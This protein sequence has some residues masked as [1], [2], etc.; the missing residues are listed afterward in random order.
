MK[1]STAS[2]AYGLGNVTFLART[3]EEEAY[4]QHVLKLRAEYIHRLKLDEMFALA[5]PPS[6]SNELFRL[7][8]YCWRQLRV[9]M[10]F[11]DNPAVQDSKPVKYALEIFSGAKKIVQAA[12]SYGIWRKPVIMTLDDVYNG[13]VS[14]LLSIKAISEQQHNQTIGFA[15]ITVPDFFNKTLS[16]LLFEAARDVC[17]QSA[18]MALSRTIAAAWGAGVGG[19][20]RT[21]ILDQGQHHMT[22]RTLE[23]PAVRP[24][25]E[26]EIIVQRVLP[27]DPYSSRH[28]DNA[29]FRQVLKSS[30]LLRQQI[31]LGANETQLQAEMAKARISIRNLGEVELD[32]SGEGENDKYHHDE[33]PLDLPNWWLGLEEKVFLSWNDVEVVEKAYVELLSTF[34][35]DYLVALRGEFGSF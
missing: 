19:D 31:E 20:T 21:L 3:G 29:F 22:I 26:R 16:D 14:S 23:E 1:S 28:I 10:T 7:L 27:V 12:T 30:P 9:Q 5:T 18:E 13:F 25:S 24:A 34:L 33:W 11:L 4:F 15:I 32:F 35:V 8:K 6:L 2:Y 17:I